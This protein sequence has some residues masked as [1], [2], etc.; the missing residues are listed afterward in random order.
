MANAPTTP[1]PNVSAPPVTPASAAGPI[2]ATPPDPVPQTAEKSMAERLA[3][4]TPF[5]GFT[6]K[7]D[8]TNGIPGYVLYW[9]NDDGPRI[10]TLLRH[11]F[12]F[13]QSNEVGVIEQVTPRNVDIGDKVCRAVGKHANGDPLYAYLMK[14]P[15][16][17]YEQD[18]RARSERQALIDAAIRGDHGR[19]AGMNVAQDG[20]TYNPVAHRGLHEATERRGPVNPLTGMQIGRTKEMG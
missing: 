2:V 16:E 14:L 20:T 4:R 17:F 12:E 3:E 19:V 1:R 15:I 6:K 7:G 18:Q 8:V 5:N 9:I 13:V 10:S 11:G